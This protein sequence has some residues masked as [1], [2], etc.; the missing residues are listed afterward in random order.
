MINYS[1]H[2]TKAVPEMVVVPACCDGKGPLRA[3]LLWIA[4]AD[5][6]CGR[7]GCFPHPVFQR[8]FL[9]RDRD[10]KHRRISGNVRMPGIDRQRGTCHRIV[11]VV[12]SRETRRYGN[13]P[14]WSRKSRKVERAGDA[15]CIVPPLFHSVLR[16][17]GRV[18]AATGRSISFFSRS[19]AP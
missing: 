18:V 14:Q 15:V 17:P 11:V 12:L 1:L 2:Y 13:H 16:R 4:L 7:T 6:S 19:P 5:R 3:L 9:R 10:E 8:L